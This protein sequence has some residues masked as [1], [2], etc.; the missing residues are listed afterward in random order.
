MSTP[1]RGE[2]LLVAVEVGKDFPALP[3]GRRNRPWLPRAKKVAK[4]LRSIGFNEV[5]G[6]HPNNA[7][8]A[9][10]LAIRRADLAGRNGTLLP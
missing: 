10:A 9:A 6:L 8:A 5:A 3:H 7:S 2:R 4:V 1:S